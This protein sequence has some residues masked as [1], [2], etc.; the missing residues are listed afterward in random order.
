MLKPDAPFGVADITGFLNKSSIETRPIICGNIAEQP[1]MQ[2][3]EHRVV[4]DL[5]HSSN[6]MHCGFSFGNHQAID[7]QARA[8]VTGKIAEFMK[9][10]GLS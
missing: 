9:S 5:R 4:G 6:V 1:A 3:Y 2:L 7:A 10:R 8:Y